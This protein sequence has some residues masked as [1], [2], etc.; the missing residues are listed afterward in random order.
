MAIFTSFG[1]RRA[2]SGGEASGLELP[3]DVRQAL[4]ARFEAVGEALAA[5]A[6][7]RPACAVVGRDV[8]RDGAALGEALDGL[9]TTYDLVLGVEP[10]FA[11]TEALSVA[12]S[13]ATLEFLH[14]LSCEDPL[15][16]LTS[17]A[18]LR[19]RLEEIYREA[20]QTAE[21]VPRDHALVVLE[22]SA[23]D[24]RQRPEHQFTRALHLVQVAEMARAVF[25]GGETIARLSTD[26]VVV[27]VRRLPHLGASVAMLRDLVGALELGATDVRVWI[28]GLPA[29]S[30][31]ARRLLDELT[32]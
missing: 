13:E 22:M 6:D 31:S 4:P 27:V 21:S 24:P 1:R 28:E 23:A 17:F 8:A 32:R 14:A 7:A 2:A 12:W 5:A 19:T 3:E 11:S 26:R 15:T 18:H 9:R 29:T 25:A 20:D 10:D 16:G 30:D